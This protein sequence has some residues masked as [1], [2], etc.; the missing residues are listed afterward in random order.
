MV[1]EAVGAFPVREQA[2]FLVTAGEQFWREATQV[3]G[4][5][6]FWRGSEDWLTEC[7]E[8]RS[9]RTPHRWFEHLGACE[10]LKWRSTGGK[11]DRLCKSSD[12]PQIIYIVPEITGSSRVFFLAL[13]PTKEGGGV[14]TCAH[15]NNC[16][17]MGS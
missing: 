12:I 2:R 9:S 1:T 7:P 6:R 3:Y 5:C 17:S 13:K 8:N 4:S 15:D 11:S 14:I 10:H 16:N